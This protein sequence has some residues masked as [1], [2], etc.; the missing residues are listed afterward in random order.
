MKIAYAWW[1]FLGSLLIA[2]PL[3]ICQIAFLV[4]HR[5]FFL[6]H[7]VTA[8]ILT[9]FVL[10]SAATIITMCHLDKHSPKRYTPV[11]NI[12]A[13]A[14]AILAAIAVIV[15][16]I[17]QIVYSGGSDGSD[18][19]EIS[20]E[21]ASQFSS[22]QEYLSILL[23][24]L[25]VVA[26]IVWLIQAAG[27]FL[28]RNLFAAHPV[29]SLFPSIWLCCTL[30]SSIIN[31]TSYV[32]L[33]ENICDMLAIM[34]LLLF[35]FAQA[36]LA[37]K[38]QI[39]RSGKGVYAFGFS[40][41][42]FVGVTALPNLFFQMEGWVTTSSLGLTFS[43]AAVCIAA[44]GA[45]YLAGLRKIPDVSEPEEIPEQPPLPE[46]EPEPAEEAPPEEP[47]EEEKAA[48][49][50]P[51]QK[52]P[53]KVHKWEEPEEDPLREEIVDIPETPAIY[54]FSKPK[55]KKKKK[56]KKNRLAA[57]LKALRRLLRFPKTAED[58]EEEEK[59]R[60]AIA[61][62]PGKWEEPSTKKLEN[63][64]MADYYGLTKD[65]EPYI[66][67][68]YD[69]KPGED[70]KPASPAAKAEDSVVEQKKDDHPPC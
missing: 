45:A 4:D 27:H 46:E 60:Q 53:R 26:G 58:L 7:G 69:I 38:Q 14:M 20:A 1:V 19:S 65:D 3:R 15:H 17:L 24:F 18:L 21:L 13:G 2:I 63:D 41:M 6:D 51:V 5:G 44:Y 12:P 48:P 9:L 47:E 10:C 29:F 57:F 25:G 64:W 30:V 43:I 70:G 40:A 23:G 35:V 56:R 59:A 8:I 50:P 42:L 22:G 68:V 66:P 32:N 36:K 61:W 31:Y 16:S 34:F 54:K 52:P 39:V 37:A 33:S 55:K 11:K 62:H 49:A 28:G 67:K